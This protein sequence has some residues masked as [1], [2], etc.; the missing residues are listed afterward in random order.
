[1]DTK[2]TRI[3]L[4]TRASAEYEEKKSVFI[5]EAAPVSSEEEAREFIEKIKKERYDA[6]HNVFAYY[7]NGGSTVRYSD[8]GEPQGTAGI[9]ILNVIK[10]SGMTDICVVVTRY[11]GGILLGTG[12][13]AR[14]YSSAAKMAMDNAGSATFTSYSVYRVETSYSDYQKILA[15]LQKIGAEEDSSDFGERITMH[16]AIRTEDAGN[17]IKTV[18]ETTYGKCVTVLEKNEERLVKNNS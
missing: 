1:M 6:R 8:D 9:P 10:M 15:S 2:E 7:L 14:A 16:I 11:F 4:A 18:S 5:A 3:T 17:L 13:L 12:G